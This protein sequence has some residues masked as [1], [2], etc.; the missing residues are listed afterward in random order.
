VA[1]LVQALVVLFKAKEV[2]LLVLA[3]PVTPYPFE[4]GGAIVEGVGHHPYLGFG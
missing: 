3:V 1:A 2:N 4:N